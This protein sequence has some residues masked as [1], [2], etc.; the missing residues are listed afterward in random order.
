MKT[1]ASLYGDRVGDLVT[2]MIV[3]EKSFVFVQYTVH[4]MYTIFV[5]LLSDG[6]ITI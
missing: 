2:I 1:A 4:I 6:I 3:N 5:Y